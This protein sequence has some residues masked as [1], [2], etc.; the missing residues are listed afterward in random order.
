[1]VPGSECFLHGER[2]REVMRK[3]DRRGSGEKPLCSN[4]TPPS[5]RL[6]QPSYL[7][8]LLVTSG[9]EAQ[10]TKGIG[11][12]WHYVL[13]DNGLLTAAKGHQPL[14]QHSRALQEEPA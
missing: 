11:T 12:I 8:V 3:Y 14:S 5:W 4:H 1:M 13:R 6:N 2:D 10:D 9:M 7:Q